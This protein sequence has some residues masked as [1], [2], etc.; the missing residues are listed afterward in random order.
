MTV[1]VQHIDGGDALLHFTAAEMATCQR[2]C[3]D[4]GD[5]PCWALPSHTSDAPREMYPCDDC[6]RDAKGPS[7]GETI[8]REHLARQGDQADD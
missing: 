1:T 5:P 2:R 8:A 3:G 4:M 7:K 6:K